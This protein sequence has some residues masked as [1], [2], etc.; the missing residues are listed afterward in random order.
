MIYNHYLVFIELAKTANFTP[1]LPLSHI[2]LIFE[3]SIPYYL[4]GSFLYILQQVFVIY[5]YQEKIY[6][7]IVSNKLQYDCC[8]VHEVTGT[9]ND[10]DNTPWCTTSGSCQA[11]SSQIP[12]TC[13]KGVTKDNYQSASSNCHASVN[14]GTFKQVYINILTYVFKYIY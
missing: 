8:A 2:S 5:V 10:F 4:L 13:C 9:T 11:T 7:S 6:I 3:L 14:S 12:K 1:G